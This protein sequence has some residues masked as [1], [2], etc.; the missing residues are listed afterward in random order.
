MT[1]YENIIEE[2]KKIGEKKLEAKLVK[3]ILNLDDDEMPINYMVKILDVSKEY[4][5]QILKEHG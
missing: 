1:T 4:V 2:G 3:A 5:I